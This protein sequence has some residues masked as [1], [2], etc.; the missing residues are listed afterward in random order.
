MTVVIRFRADQATYIR[1]REWHP[2]QKVRDLRDGRVELTF[3]AGGIYE[4][5]RWVLSW[6]NAAEVI[7]PARLRREL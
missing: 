7:R 2:T 6:G 1:E 3:R 5:I 4:I